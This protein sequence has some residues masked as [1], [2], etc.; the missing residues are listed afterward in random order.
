MSRS[1]HAI[2]FTGPVLDAQVEYG[3]RAA[4][5]HLDPGSVPVQDRRWAMPNARSSPS[6][7]IRVELAHA[8]RRE[9]LRLGTKLRRCP[10]GTSFAIW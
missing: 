8:V 5:D 1:Y 4:I 2:A 10:S 6:G 9:E 7:T 3:S